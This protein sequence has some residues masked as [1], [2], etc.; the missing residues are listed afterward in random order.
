M[1]N[2]VLEVDFLE[3]SQ[4]KLKK[5]KD[6]QLLSLAIILKVSYQFPN[7]NFQLFYLR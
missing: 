1:D 6:G 7:E 3:I 4:P 5:S 2:K